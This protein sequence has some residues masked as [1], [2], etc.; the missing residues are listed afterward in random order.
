ML[1]AVGCSKEGGCEMLKLT[2]SG[3][4]WVV[5]SI[6]IAMVVGCD[7]LSGDVAPDFTNNYR[8]PRPVV[9]EECE[10]FSGSVAKQRC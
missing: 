4:I 8:M 5:V 2:A 1:D 6:G 10:S 3:H 9:G 7:S